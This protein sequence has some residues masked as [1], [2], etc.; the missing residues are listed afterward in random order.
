MKIAIILGSVRKNRKSSQVGVYLKNLLDNRDGVVP[1]L[2]DLVEFPFPVM[3]ERFRNLTHPPAG[4]VEFSRTLEEADGI[5]II[6]P[7]YNGS[8]SGALKNTLDYF[9]QEYV[10]KPMGIVTVSSGIWGGVNASHHLLAWVLHVEAI[11]SPFKLMVQNINSLFNNKGE[12]TDPDFEARA[13]KFLD[14]FLWLTT[15]ISQVN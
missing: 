11:P 14:E 13:E 2:L 3:E 7:E 12:L 5:V 9:K 4:M 10:K 1:K 8:Y 6:T 15:A